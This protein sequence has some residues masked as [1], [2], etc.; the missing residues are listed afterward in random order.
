M[1]KRSIHSFELLV[2]SIASE[3]LMQIS[4]I[5]WFFLDSCIIR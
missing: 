2:E 1:S 3:R 4:S 5:Y